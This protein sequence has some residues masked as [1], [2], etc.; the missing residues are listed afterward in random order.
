M[1]S[2]NQ[3]QSVSLDYALDGFGAYLIRDRS[4]CSQGDTRADGAAARYRIQ[5]G[6]EAFSACGWGRADSLAP[7]FGRAD[8]KN[9]LLRLIARKVISWTTQR[10]KRLY[11]YSALSAEKRRSPIFFKQYLPAQ[12]GDMETR[13]PGD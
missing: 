8:W 4:L 2:R 6:S 3:V 5:Q 9:G 13:W 12:P 10:K 11:R 7:V 1:Q